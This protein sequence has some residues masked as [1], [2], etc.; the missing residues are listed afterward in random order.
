MSKIPKNYL[1]GQGSLV[2]S[3]FRNDNDGM[4]KPMAG[5]VADAIEKLRK[6][7]DSSM[8]LYF[9]CQDCGKAHIIKTIK[10]GA[11]I[12]TEKCK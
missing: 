9:D 1:R 11:V 12:E 4:P 6:I 7:P 10:F 5:T 3:Q 2:R 8:P